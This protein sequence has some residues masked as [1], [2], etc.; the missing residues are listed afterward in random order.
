MSERYKSREHLEVSLNATALQIRKEKG[1]ELSGDGEPFFGDSLQWVRGRAAAFVK[2]SD[3]RVDADDLT[4][5]V[6]LKVRQY[7]PNFRGENGEKYTSWLFRIT[8]RRFF[9]LRFSEA[10]TI[11]ESSL[12]NDPDDRG[13]ALEKAL[14]KYSGRAQDVEIQ[15]HILNDQLWAKIPWNRLRKGD[16]EILLLWADGTPGDE[17]AAFRG[18]APTVVR[19][20]I[21]RALNL[22]RKSVGTKKSATAKGFKKKRSHLLANAQR[23]AG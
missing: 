15:E 8:Q 4:H 11:N 14:R 7:F 23:A 16:K 17:I 21:R 3:G 1:W 20:R 2:G 12:T 5:E 10:K 18:M 9:D 13:S 22:I 6:M 19:T